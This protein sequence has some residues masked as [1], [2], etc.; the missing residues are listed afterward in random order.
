[1]FTQKL[2]A[3]PL[4]RAMGTLARRLARIRASC[5]ARSESPA[6]R[7]QALLRDWLSPEQL[8]Q[9]EATSTFDVVG[10]HSGRRYRIHQ[11]TSMNVTEID[12]AGGAIIGW[13]FLPSGNLVA[14]DVMLAQKIALEKDERAALSVARRF[15]VNIPR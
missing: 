10:C 8:A 5:R 2:V 1:M 6:V 11:G 14:G 4:P 9:F 13:C 3:R 12:D 7:G 15:L